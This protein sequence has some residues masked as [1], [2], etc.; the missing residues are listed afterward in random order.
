MIAKWRTYSLNGP[1]V[2][3]SRGGHVGHSASTTVIRSSSTSN[4]S[5]VSGRA[6]VTPPATASGVVPSLSDLIEDLLQERFT[7]EQAEYSCT[8][9]ILRSDRLARINARMSSDPFR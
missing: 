4:G 7:I 1:G 9:V 5:R 6:I 8:S 3:L 2:M